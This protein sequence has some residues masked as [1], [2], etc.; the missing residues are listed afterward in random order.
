[1]N[2]S[3]IVSLKSAYTALD[4]SANRLEEVMARAKGKRDQATLS[5]DELVQHYQ[6]PTD[7]DFVALDAL[8][9]QI[10]RALPGQVGQEQIQTA[11]DSVKGSALTAARDQKI[12]DRMA[13][14]SGL[15]ALFAAAK[16]IEVTAQK[17][18]EKGARA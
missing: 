15:D 10:A 5:Q 2:A 17:Q 4:Q 6:G 1:M 13:L 8:I 18:A 3:N 11:V 14:A 9:F 16:Q 12:T 7:R